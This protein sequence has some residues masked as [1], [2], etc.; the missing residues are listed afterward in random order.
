MYCHGASL[1]LV[2]QSC[3]ILCDPTDCSPPGSSVYRDYPGKD[4]GV[5]C[6]ALLQGLFPTQGLNPGIKSTLQTD[7]LPSEPPKSQRIETVP[8]FN[9]TNFF[10][11]CVS[12]PILETK[13]SDQIRSVLQSCPILCNPMNC[14]LTGSSNHGIF[15]ARVLEWGAIAF[16]RRS[17]LPRD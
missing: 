8:F 2:F 16:S 10:F 11:C 5:G 3:S 6:H 12:F 13:V 15:Q 17:S 4:T 1:C 14:S 7:F 9:C